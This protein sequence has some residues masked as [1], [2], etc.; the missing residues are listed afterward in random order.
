MVRIHWGA[1]SFDAYPM[2]ASRMRS[3][4]SS[5]SLATSDESTRTTRYPARSSAASRRASDV[6]V[7]PLQS[8]IRVSLFGGHRGSRRLAAGSA[9]TAAGHFK[10]KIRVRIR[11]AARSLRLALELR[12]IDSIPQRAE[13]PDESAAFPTPSE[14]PVTTRRFREAAPPDPPPRAAARLRGA[15]SGVEGPGRAQRQ[16][17]EHDRPRCDTHSKEQHLSWIERRPPEP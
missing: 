13:P 2:S 4:A 14:L 16:R 7:S 5:M 17:R 6:R 3:R 8:E 11:T 12:P 9:L 1:Q 15:A 10:P